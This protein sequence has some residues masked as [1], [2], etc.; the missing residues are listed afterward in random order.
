MPAPEYVAAQRA[1]SVLAGELSAAFSGTTTTPHHRPI[2]AF[3]GNGT[4]LMAASNLVGLAS[5]AAPLAHAR[6]AGAAPTSRRRTVSSI[7][8]FA[9]PYGDGVAL[10]LA[11]AWQ[12]ASDAHL[13]R[14]P[15]GEVEDS[16]K[17]TA[18]DARSRCRTV[19]S[20]GWWEGSGG[21]V[22]GSGG[23]GVPSAR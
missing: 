4:D 6:V 12:A 20:G 22:T 17:V 8:F 16:V 18:C 2:H 5:V 3:I 7:G 15:V 9:P 11:T 13:Q 21:N 10:A 19:G 23:G 1:R 14:P